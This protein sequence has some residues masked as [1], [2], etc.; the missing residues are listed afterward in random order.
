M[1][2]SNR[3]GVPLALLFIDLDRFKQINDTHGHAAGDDVL[4]Y[5]AKVLM[6][7]FRADDLVARV[8]GDEFAVLAADLT[9]RQAES[10]M[11]GVLARITGN[12][13][14]ED[15]PAT[16]PTLSCGLAEYSAGDTP[17]NTTDKEPWNMGWCARV[18]LLVA[19]RVVA[20]ER[21]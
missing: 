21:K 18:G 11:A 13:K 16:M 19:R 20:A 12:D 7:S 15:R 10:R 17:E 1:K 6:Q 9:I 8:G 5:V 3:T 4:R 2:K 14:T